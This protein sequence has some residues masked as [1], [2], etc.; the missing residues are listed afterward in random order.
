MLNLPLVGL[1]VKLV[2]IPYKYLFPIVICF[3]CIGVFSI[4]SSPFA[5]M[6]MAGFGVFGYMLKKLECEPAP[7]ILGFILGPMMEGHMQRA[8]LIARGDFTV[9]IREPISAALL[10]VSAAALVAVILPSVRKTRDVAL[11]D[12]E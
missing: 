4:S 2:S 7:M 12:D 8:L 1:W 3:A 11:I 6:T 9:F 10:F 5:V